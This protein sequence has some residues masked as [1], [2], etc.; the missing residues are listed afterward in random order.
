[1]DFSLFYFANNSRELDSNRY[2]LLLDGAKFADRNGFA[3]V[4][5]PERHF[6][7]F[8]GLYPNPSV[9]GAAVAAVTE[10]IQIRAGS[11][12]APLHNPLRIAEDLCVLDNLSRGRLSLIIGAGYAP[13][14]FEMFDVELRERPQRVTELV[15]TLR[16]AFTGEPFEYH[17]RTVQITPPPYQPGGPR[18][19]LGGASE[20]AARR[21]ARI[22]D[23]FV[24]STGDV[25]EFYARLVIESRRSGQDEEVTVAF[26]K[27]GIKRL[28]A[29]FANLVILK[30]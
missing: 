24:P 6:H 11:V 19:S 12:V 8:G 17:D 5:T 29:S 4:W 26:E 1:M 25:W 30:D 16:N 2:G 7:S 27:H 13:H 9:T 21:A 28:A 14:E 23:G 10:R 20:G 22:G 18:I 15:T 3:A